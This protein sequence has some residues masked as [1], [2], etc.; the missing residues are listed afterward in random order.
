VSSKTSGGTGWT[1]HSRGLFQISVRCTIAS[2]A[3]LGFSRPV[4]QRV[5]RAPGGFSLC[6]NLEFRLGAHVPPKTC[7]RNVPGLPRK[8]VIVNVRL[9][10]QSTSLTMCF[11]QLSVDA[12]KLWPDCDS[13]HI[14]V[15]DAERPSEAVGCAQLIATQGWGT[16]MSS[17]A[18]AIRENWFE[19]CM[20]TLG[21]VHDESVYGAIERLVEAGSAVGLTVVDLIRM[22]RNGMTL[23][24]LL[25]LIE[26]RMAA[27]P[28]S[29]RPWA[30]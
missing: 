6:S 21:E 3:G 13:R 2:H 18:E 23:E 4:V 19:E 20:T 10:S 24:S 15:L 25:D 28:S 9:L 11:W 8:S 1:Y 7:V 27:T 5:R 30:A 22:L 14:H 12:E 16:K 29:T 26:I 17:R